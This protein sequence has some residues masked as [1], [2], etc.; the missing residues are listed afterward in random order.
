MH[1]S[2]DSNCFNPLRPA[3]VGEIRSGRGQH[4]SNA[5]FNPLRPA[6]V[7]EMSRVGGLSA[8]TNVSIH[9]DQR[10]SEKSSESDGTRHVNTCFNPLRPALVGEI[11]ERQTCRC[12]AE[13][14]QST[15][16]SAGRRN[17][18]L[19]RHPRPRVSI[20]S[21]QRWSEKC[22]VASRRS[23]WS[24]FNPLRPALVG[25][26]S[27][28]AGYSD[29]TPVFQ[30]TPTSA[31]RRNLRRL[32]VRVIDQSFQSTPT[33]AGRRN[34]WPRFR[35]RPRITFQSTPTSAGRRNPTALKRP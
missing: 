6:L 7:G 17:R 9:S 24:S 20:H 29:W 19:R 28:R 13:V 26:I 11:C 23:A 4:E 25:E 27:S 16:T 14:F 31:G 22:L 30:S 34:P 35:L 10:W 8:A 3:L 33:S 15:P 18:S 5:C 12:G 21:D 32:G 1:G 2:M